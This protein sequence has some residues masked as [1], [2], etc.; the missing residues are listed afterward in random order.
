M[1]EPLRFILVIK[2]L[3]ILHAE[4]HGVQKNNIIDG[5]GSILL[6]LN[7]D[8]VYYWFNIAVVIYISVDALHSG[9]IWLRTSILNRIR[10]KME[11]KQIVNE[12]NIYT[13]HFYNL[14]HG[15]WPF[16]FLLNFLKDLLYCQ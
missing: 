6:L 13:N 9:H 8:I 1:N 10:D 2:K 16:I 12:K 3:S 7:V 4:I 15:S 11:K 5:Y 14:T